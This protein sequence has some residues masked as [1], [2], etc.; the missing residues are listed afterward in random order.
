MVI[1]T[2]IFV[3]GS[4]VYAATNRNITSTLGGSSGDT[5]QLDGTLQVSSLKVGA[6]GT[7]G[8]TFFNGTIVNNTTTKG[9]NNPVTFGDNVRIDGDIYR[10]AT[11][12]TND[13]LPLK[14]NDN[15][16]ISGSLT[17]GGTLAASSVS[18]SG[19]SSGL[20][21]TNVQAALD[22]VK[23]LANIR[24][25]RYTGSFNTGDNGDEITTEDGDVACLNPTYVKY[26]RYHWK[27]IAVPEI[28]LNNMPSIKVYNKLYEDFDIFPTPDNLWIEMSAYSLAA[29][30]Q[31]YVHLLYKYVYE[32]CD[33][34]VETY[35]F[36]TGEYK[37]VIL[38]T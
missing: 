15:V 20:S 21:S 22:E 5:F 35:P 36:T 18:Y 37:I 1:I 31:G 7:G 17:L 33:G 10:G 32:N 38:H 30:S 3:T 12:G 34:T 8:V 6:Q 14:I 24:Y 23:S 4:L 26:T 25:D 2:S 9:V 19:S 16:N 29:Y 28:D 13:S 11:I 27:K